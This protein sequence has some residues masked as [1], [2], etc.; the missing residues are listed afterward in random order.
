MKLFEKLFGGK[1]E[2]GTDPEIIKKLEEE[3]TE[4]DERAEEQR[5]EEKDEEAQ[6]IEELREKIAGIEENIEG[7]GNKNPALTEENWQDGVNKIRADRDNIQEQIDN[8]NNSDEAEKREQK[9]N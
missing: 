9:I 8:E 7:S 4:I 2:I 1:E 5:K 3:T 6:K